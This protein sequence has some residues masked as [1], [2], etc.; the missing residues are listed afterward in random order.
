LK[1]GKKRRPG[2]GEGGRD[3]DDLSLREKKWEGGGITPRKTRWEGDFS[4]GEI[5]VKGKK[6]KGG[7]RSNHD[8]KNLKLGE[9]DLPSGVVTGGVDERE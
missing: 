9:N 7:A 3:F 1:G 5:I 4:G 2:G 6:K 8:K